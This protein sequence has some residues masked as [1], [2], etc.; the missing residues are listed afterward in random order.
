MGSTRKRFSQEYKDS[1]V[2][3]VLDDGRSIAGVARDIGAHEVTV[4]K[5][6]KKAKESGKRPEKPLTESER[7]ELLRLREEV[8]VARM[9]AEFAKKV[10]T[11]FAKDQR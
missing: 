1:V 8:K 3:L 4:G 5:W 2:S 11:W 6:V 9:E 10:A 7:A